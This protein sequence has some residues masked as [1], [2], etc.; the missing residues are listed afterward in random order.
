MVNFITILMLLGELISVLLMVIA[1][2]MAFKVWKDNRNPI[3]L[4][5][6]FLFLSVAIGIFNLSI[7]ASLRD[8]G[9]IDQDSQLMIGQLEIGYISSVL[10]ASFYL[11]FLVFLLGWQKLYSLPLVVGFYIGVYG[12]L[13]GNLDVVFGY[14]TFAILPSIVILMIN[15]IK[16]KHGLS[17]TLSIVAIASVL[18]TV[19]DPSTVWGFLIKWVGGISIILGENGW[20]DDHIFYDRVKRKK[21]QNVWIAR[22]TTVDK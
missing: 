7:K 2:V 21:I 4:G 17:F 16:N 20:F 12:I 19:I 6:F 9:L 10:I 15:A 14:V 22:M 3:D 5:T 11:W 13:I 8:L 1:I 18:V